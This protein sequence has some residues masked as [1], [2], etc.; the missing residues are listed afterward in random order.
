MRLFLLS[1]CSALC[2]FSSVAFAADPP[3]PAPI[4]QLVKDGAVARY[5]GK[6]QNLDGWVTFK[7]GQEQYFYVTPDGQGIIMGLLFNTR[8]DA[9][10]L[11][12]IDQ[13]RER[14]GDTL[15]KL[16]GVNPAVPAV[17]KP[18]TEPQKNTVAT[19]PNSKSEQFYADIELA[20]WI[21]LGEKTAPPFY[22]FIDPQ[23]P[24]CKDMIKEFQNS[25]ALNNIQLRLLPVGLLSED[26][27][28]QAAFLLASPTAGA[29]LLKL[30]GGDQSAIPIDKN[31]PLLGVQKNLSLMQTYK[32]DV[33]PFAVYKT[34]D[35]TV[36]I[37]RGVPKNM[38]A[39]IKEIKG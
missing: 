8:G 33:T 26:S 12:Q 34:K 39:L 22:A 3:M 1:S 2:L 6:D 24:H 38:K 20:N 29:D 28:A 35:G 16:A 14:E 32:I 19:K 30:V 36:K 37:L 9:I 31:L 13:L 27:L 5:L 17:N 10:T 7:N 25:G 15:D 11:R 18:T 21:V 4:Q 23:C